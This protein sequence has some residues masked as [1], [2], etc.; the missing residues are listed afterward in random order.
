M[1]EYEFTTNDFLKWCISKSIRRNDISHSDL[2][3]FVM[4]K[5]NRVK[6]TG[7]KCFPDFDAG[8]IK[9][10]IEKMKYNTRKVN[11]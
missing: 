9:V 10:R 2:I 7:I 11:T 1:K 6:S 3:H 4:E 8:T 5:V